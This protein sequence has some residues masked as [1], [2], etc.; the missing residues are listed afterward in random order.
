LRS[1]SGSLAK[2]A[3]ILAEMPHRGAFFE[4]VAAALSG[5]IR[6]LFG[7]NSPTYSHRSLLCPDAVFDLVRCSVAAQLR[8][9]FV[10]RVEAL[11]R[12]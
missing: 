3:A 5:L 9:T 11:A 6:Q 4:A 7:L 1:K 8:C 2:L 10:G 12:K